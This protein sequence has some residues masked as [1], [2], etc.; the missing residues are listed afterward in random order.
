LITKNVKKMK[1]LFSLVI[2][3]IVIVA[4]SACGGKKNT[5]EAVAE[6]FLGHLNKKEYAEAKKLGTENTKQ[7]L[8]MMESFSGMDKKA[9]VKDVKIE[10]LKCETTEDKAKCTYTAEAKEET[11]DLVKQDGNW[12]VDM[13]K[14]GNGETPPTT[15][16]TD[17]TAAVK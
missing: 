10:N 16:T 3:A 2:V 1:K 12:L 4:V 15:P 14:E 7:M 17:S 5:P 6:K 9:E 11:I 13:K 8:D